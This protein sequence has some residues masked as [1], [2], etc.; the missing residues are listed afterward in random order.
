M[1]ILDN[2]NVVNIEGLIQDYKDDT[3]LDENSVSDMYGLV[4][5]VVEGAEEIG[6]TP[7]EVTAIVME[8]SGDQETASNTAEEEELVE[9]TRELLEKIGDEGNA[10]NAMDLEKQYTGE[11]EGGKEVRDQQFD[12]NAEEREI[13]VEDKISDIRLEKPTGTMDG[14]VGRVLK[15]CE[16]MQE[17]QEMKHVNDA[18]TTTVSGH[19]KPTGDIGSVL[20]SKNA[21]NNLEA[22]KPIGEAN[23]VGNAL[24]AETRNL[25]PVM[26]S[27]VEDKQKPVISKEEIV[28]QGGR[29][30]DNV[31]NLDFQLIREKETVVSSNIDAR[32]IADESGLHLFDEKNVSGQQ[33]TSYETSEGHGGDEGADF[34]ELPVSHRAHE[35]TDAVISSGKDV[36][37]HPNGV[38]YDEAK[39]WRQIDAMR[40]IVGYKATPHATCI[41]ELKA[42]YLFTGVEPPASFGDH[43]DLAQ[44][45]LRAGK[46]NE[47]VLKLFKATGKD[48]ILSLI[49]ALNIRHT[50]TP[51]FP[52]SNI[53]DN[54]VDI[55]IAAIN[56]DLE[57]F[58]NEWRPVFSQFHLIIVKDP[59]MNGELHIPE[60]F[61]VDVFTKSDIDRVVGSSTSIL[62]SGYSCRYFGYLVSRK[63]YIISIDDDCIPARDT[64]GDL[65]EQRNS[66]YVDAVMTVPVRSLMPVSGINIAF[67]REVVG[68][69]LFPALRLAGEGKLRWETVEDIWSGMCVKVICDHLGLGVKSGI[70][71]VW[72]RERGDAI[73]SLKKEWEGVKLMEEVVPFFQSV[74]LPQTAVTAE[75]CVVD[76]A[77][78]VKE[79]LGKVDPMFARAA[80]AMG[81][82]VKLWKS[83]G[84]RSPGV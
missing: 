6:L 14:G 19:V 44:K 20:E 15:E 72:R 74:R 29:A 25:R 27:I 75:D 79:Q 21:D 62:F 8:E 28:L 52:T 47:K 77:K 7:I 64:N 54:E 33:Y 76:M 56:S 81:D 39:I 80:D 24:E 43:P 63:K 4:S 3:L 42:L 1:L 83:V 45:T 70:P 26:S 9:E 36:S 84:S 37:M 50:L 73:E 18:N 67:N 38:P 23:D 66:R 78:S 69:A 60:G 16:D 10:D 51:V 41:E 13:L 34:A 31:N 55:V 22:E 2:T 46:L 65:P 57:P 71:Y 49:Q 35:S 30:E 32:E 17:P 59:D 12:W 5:N 48:E 40:R 58:M 61:N 11:V 53:N 68:P 82:W